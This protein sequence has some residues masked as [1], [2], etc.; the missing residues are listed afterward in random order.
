MAGLAAND[1]NAEEYS[2]TSHAQEVIDYVHRLSGSG[3]MFSESRIR[4][5]LEAARRFAMDAKPA[6]LRRLDDVRA[7][8]V[9]DC[10]GNERLWCRWGR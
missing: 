2:L 9:T 8:L 7:L 6:R 4:T 5:I 10:R 1:D 3:S